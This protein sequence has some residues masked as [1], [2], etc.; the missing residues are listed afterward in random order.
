MPCFVRWRAPANY[1]G[2]SEAQ[3]APFASSTTFSFRNM[4][5]VTIP[6]SMSLGQKQVLAGLYFLQ[7]TRPQSTSG[8]SLPPLTL[9]RTVTT[10]RGRTTWR[11]TSVVLTSSRA[12]S[13]VGDVAQMMLKRC[14]LVTA[15]WSVQH[16]MS[17]DEHAAATT[18]NPDSADLSTCCFRIATRQQ[19]CWHVYHCHSRT[20]T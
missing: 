5:R 10:P 13:S 4:L 1:R 17:K 7:T 6:L 15:C 2:R 18:W 8:T 16:A 14:R 12:S 20:S 11:A 9:R 19:A 3:M